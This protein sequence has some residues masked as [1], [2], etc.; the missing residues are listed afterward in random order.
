MKR[1]IL[2]LLV[3]AIIGVFVSYNI[4]QTQ[5][6]VENISDLAM[7]N[8]E[9]LANSRE[10]YMEAGTCWGA[11]PNMTNVTCYG[12]YVICCW[13]HTDVFGKN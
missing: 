5:K 8:I 10:L 1:K 4:Y 9:A 6:N 11:G 7:S 13:A 2:G 3:V 12:G